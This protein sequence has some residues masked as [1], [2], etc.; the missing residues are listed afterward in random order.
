ML[1]H[2][3]FWPANTKAGVTFHSEI[4]ISPAVMLRTYYRSAIEAEGLLSGSRRILNRVKRAVQLVI[5]D[6]EV[7]GYPMTE[8]QEEF[9]CLITR[10]AEEVVAGLPEKEQ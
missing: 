1:T 5:R 4:E 3:N 8:T 10:F 9:L 6:V 7:Q 2:S